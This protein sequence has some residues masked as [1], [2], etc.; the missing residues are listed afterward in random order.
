MSTMSDPTLG[1]V[2]KFRVERTD[3]SSAPGQKHH[4]CRTYVL[5]LDHDRHAIPA[6]MA[7]IQSARAG[8][9]GRL[10]SDL[11]RW[12][13]SD[14]IA[15]PNVLYVDTGYRLFRTPEGC[16]NVRSNDELLPEFFGEQLRALE[17]PAVFDGKILRWSQ[18]STQ[19]RKEWPEAKD[20]E[21]FW[22]GEMRAATIGE[23]VAFFR[24]PD[25][26]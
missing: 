4:Q 11:D 20:C 23:I 19:E 12:L 17:G 9:F 10:A 22:L 24:M 6:L 25:A 7:Y 26:L 3:G 14:A 15:A 13:G 1:M 16:L 2:N 5:D 21:A 8:A 18:M